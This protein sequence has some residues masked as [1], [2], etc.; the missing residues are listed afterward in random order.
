MK[1]F[2]NSNPFEPGIVSTVQPKGWSLYTAKAH[3]PV[4]VGEVRHVGAL[5]CDA[6]PLPAN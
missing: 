2:Q 5:L 4:V 6:A 1:I 3:L